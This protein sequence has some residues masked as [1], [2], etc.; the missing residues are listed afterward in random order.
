MAIDI[1]YGVLSKGCSY[2]YVAKFCGFHT[3]FH[4]DTHKD[5]D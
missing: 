3:G 1:L 4:G 2:S 5:S